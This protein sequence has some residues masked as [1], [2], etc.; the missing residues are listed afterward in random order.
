[1]SAWR[2]AI[3]LHLG[4]AVW[5][6]QTLIYGFFDQTIPKLNPPFEIEHRL[7]RNDISEMATHLIGAPV[8]NA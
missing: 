1:M 2:C 6:S 7:H 5:V 4:Q 8:R 3:R